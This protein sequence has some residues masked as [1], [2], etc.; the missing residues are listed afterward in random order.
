[1]TRT[2]AG[3][4]AR[5]LTFDDDPELYMFGMLCALVS[6]GTWLLLATYLELPVST[7]HSIGA[8]GDVLVVNMQ[9]LDA[10]V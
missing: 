7:T 3:G 10:M 1:M 4:I 9:S 8:C 5:L 2:V 6:S